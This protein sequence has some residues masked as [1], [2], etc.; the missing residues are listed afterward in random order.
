MTVLALRYDT[1]HGRFRQGRRGAR[2]VL[3]LMDQPKPKPI[4]L[5]ALREQIQ[6][7]EYVVD[8][9]KVADAIVDRLVLVSAP[10]R[11]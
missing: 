11:R 6:R 9:H 5:D 8:P 1:P 3:T 4:K 10:P 2:D 7:G